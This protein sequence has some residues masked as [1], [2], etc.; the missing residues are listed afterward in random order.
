M[1]KAILDYRVAG[2]GNHPAKEQAFGG[3]DIGHRLGDGFIAPGCGFGHRGLLIWDHIARMRVS[4]GLSYWN[5][6]GTSVP[7]SVAI[8]VLMVR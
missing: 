1:N 4:I 7:A 8:M 6:D 2:A 5:R 3:R